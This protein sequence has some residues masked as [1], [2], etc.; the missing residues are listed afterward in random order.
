MPFCQKQ[1]Y[2]PELFSFI[3]ISTDFDET[4]TV[5]DTSVDPDFDTAML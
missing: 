3:L 2:L 4:N 1:K 5:K